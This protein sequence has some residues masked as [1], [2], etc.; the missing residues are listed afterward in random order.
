MYIFLKTPPGEA[1]SWIK[2]FIDKCHEFDNGTYKQ[3]INGANARI[4]RQL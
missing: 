3:W 1:S 4:E 2:E